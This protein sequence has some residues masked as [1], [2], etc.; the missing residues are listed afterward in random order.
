MTLSTKALLTFLSGTEEID[1][2][3]KQNYY[4]KYDFKGYNIHLWYLVSS[5]VESQNKDCP[6]LLA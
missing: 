2:G 4:S 1:R 3:A 5:V 6:K